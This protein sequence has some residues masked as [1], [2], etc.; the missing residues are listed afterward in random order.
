MN[1]HFNQLFKVGLTRQVADMAPAGLSYR[2]VWSSLIVV[3]VVGIILLESS[4]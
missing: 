2:I 1:S 4:G 3:V